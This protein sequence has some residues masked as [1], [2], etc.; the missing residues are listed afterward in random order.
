MFM[1][2]ANSTRSDKGEQGSALVIAV[3]VLV[4][5]GAL[6]L[7]ALDVAELNLFM[8]ANDRDSKEAFFHADSGVN[9]GR[10]LIKELLDSGN[11]TILE[12]NA[13]SWA[14]SETFVASDYNLY[15]DSIKKT[16]VRAGLIDYVDS[17]HSI[18]YND[19]I[20][21][22]A[23]LGKSLAPIFLIRSHN[24]GKRNS[25]A[26]VDLGWRDRPLM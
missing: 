23:S 13:K 21:P 22:G 1:I 12:N 26:E 4:I 9:I 18:Q 25:R 6:G 2:S 16:F 5:L 14:D 19:Y 17:P 11:M 10:E 24:E 20:S 8:A 7:T 3:I 15:I